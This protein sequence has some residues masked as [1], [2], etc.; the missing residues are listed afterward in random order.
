MILAGDIG[1]TKAEFAVFEDVQSRK[2]LKEARFVCKEYGS[3][4]EIISNFLKGES[5]SITHVCFGIAGP[6]EKNIC[7]ATNLPWV[8][9]GEKLEKLIPGSKVFLINDLLANA[10]GVRCLR[11]DEL[12]VVASGSR[13]EG[14]KALI[15]AGTGLG[16]AGFYFDGTTHH[17]FAS[18]GGH[19]N[20]A[21]SNQEEEELLHYFRGKFDGHVS[22]ERFLCGKGIANIYRF[23]VEIKKE[24]ELPEVKERM[25][26]EDPAKVIYEFAVNKKC[27]ICIKTVKRFIAIYGSEASNL[28]LKYLAVG[29][30]YIGGGIAPKML[31]AFKDG[32]F[33][34]NFIN[35][36]RFKGLLSAVPIHL[37]LNPKTALLGAAQY[38]ENRK[39]K[40][41]V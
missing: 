16:E 18:E 41:G 21:P 13:K 27:P 5:F 17:P 34:E 7:Q 35:K 24:E 23:W 12:Y 11:N 8:I 32:V 14:N 10:Y 6:I 30:V 3:L 20:F 40:S 33:L 15:S 38:A 22:F 28:A 31:D 36:G 29:G 2:T 39:N 19:C 9:E 4:E 25:E 1:G 37:I 26:K